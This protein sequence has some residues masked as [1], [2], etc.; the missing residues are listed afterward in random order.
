MEILIEAVE[1]TVIR[2]NKNILRN[3]SLIINQNNFITIIGPN[4]A[5]KTTLLKC[6]LGLYKPDKG[7]VELKRGLRIGYVPQRPIFDHKIP[8]TVESFLRLRKKTNV[9]CIKKISEEVSI[10]HLLKKQLSLLS[11]G[12]L[13]RVMLARSLLDNPELLVLDEP[14]QNLDISGQL[15]FYKLLKRLYGERQLSILMVSHDLH[16][17]MA[18]SEEVVCLFHHICCSGKP[19][20]VIRDPKFISIFGKEM[21]NIMGIY[22]HNHSHNHE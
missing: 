21:I 18:S 13:Q 20:D 16:L 11:G 8:I 5:G 22:Q 15:E 2:Q 1:I 3:V 6:L 10:M 19:Q 17:V 4:G 7:M 14:A 12:E 9:L